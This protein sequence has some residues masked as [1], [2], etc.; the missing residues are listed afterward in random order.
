[1]FQAVTQVQEM[2]LTFVPKLVGISVMLTIMGSWILTQL[3]AFTHLCFDRIAAIG[4]L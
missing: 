4:R 1:V 2:T 3:V